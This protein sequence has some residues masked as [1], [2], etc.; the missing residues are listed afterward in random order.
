MRFQVG[1]WESAFN[2]EGID[3]GGAEYSLTLRALVPEPGTVALLGLGLGLVG[4]GL[5]R[6]ERGH[7][8]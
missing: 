5:G 6:R 2:P 8:N 7:D 4:L 3:E 1:A